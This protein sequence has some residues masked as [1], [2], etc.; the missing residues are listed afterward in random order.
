[1][2]KKLRFL[3][4]LFLAAAFMIPSL[5]IADPFESRPH[6]WKAKHTFN[7]PATFKDQ[8]KFEST[9]SLNQYSKT[10]YVDSESGAD[11]PHWGKTWE[12]PFDTIEY[13][14]SQCVANRGDT[15]ILLYGH[16]EAITTAAGIDFDIAGITVV[17]QGS[18]VSGMA[19]ID[20]DNTAA[21]TAIGANNITLIGLRFRA[22]A[23]GV[24]M[25]VRVEDGVTS[26]S[27]IN[28]EFGYAEDTTDEF[29]TAIGFGDASNYGLVQGCK[30]Y[31]G[32][33]AAV[34][35]ILFNKDTDGTIIRDNLIM[36]DYS[37]ACINGIETASTNL[38]IHNN[39]LY[40][41][42]PTGNNTEP[43]IELLTGSDGVI[44][45]NYISADLTTKA[46]A[47]VCD[48]CF[49]FENYYCE[50]PSGATTGGIIGTASADDG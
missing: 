41:A 18:G 29:T 27:I 21:T 7:K 42:S 1:M 15:I 38:F 13:A 12:E 32:A 50:T 8:V 49:L 40:N 16:N 25:G 43:G 19:S 31:G 47:I 22:S 11:I 9:V 5:A 37:T 30:F 10:F 4:V 35:A 6:E 20:F 17:G 2:S 23:S 3:S 24:T 14:L 33:Q 46:A 36:G 39:I 44:S 28:C 26:A 48:G 34:Q 45:D